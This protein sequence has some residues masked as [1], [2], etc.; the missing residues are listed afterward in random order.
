MY[1]RFAQAVYGPVAS[2]TDGMISDQLNLILDI[3]GNLGIYHSYLWNQRPCW[4]VGLTPKKIP[5]D[6]GTIYKATCTPV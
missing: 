6:S 1:F 3:L 5:H 4:A 2:S